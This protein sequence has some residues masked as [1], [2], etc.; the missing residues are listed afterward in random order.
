MGLPGALDPA[1]KPLPAV[2]DPFAQNA[3]TSVYEQYGYAG[4]TWHTYDLG[5]GGSVRDPAAATDTMIGNVLLSCAVWLT[6]ATNGL[7]NKVA[8]PASYMGPLDDVV[9]TVT[10]RLHDSIWSPWGTVAVLGVGALLLFQAMRAHFPAVVAGAAWAALVLAVVA[11]ITQYPSRAS[12]FFDDTITSTIGSMQART[13]G[14]DASTT[15]GESS[16]RAQ[17]A[18]TVDRVLYDAWLRGQL[19]SSDSFAA[20][21]WGSALFQASA[22]SWSE[23]ESASTPEAINQL[24]EEKAEQWKETADEIA[25]QDPA[26]YA[27]LQGK[28][29]GRMGTGLMALFGAVF[30]DLFRLVADVFLLAG[31]VMLRLL[32]MFLP[33]AAVIGVFAPLSG[34]VKQMANMGGA[35]VVN[36]VAFSAGSVVYTAAI[37]AVLSTA[38]DIGMGVMVLVLCLVITLA[39]FV[40]MAPLLS[41]TRILGHSGRRMRRRHLG[42]QLTRYVVTRQ[43]VND[44][45]KKAIED[46]QAEAPEATVPTEGGGQRAA[47]ASPRAETF[48]R[49]QVVWDVTSDRGLSRTSVS[50]QSRV[51]RRVPMTRAAL[52]VSSDVRPDAS[53]SGQRYEGSS[54]WR[55]SAPT[56]ASKDGREPC[57]MPPLLDVPRSSHSVLTGQILTESLDRGGHRS[58]GPA[59]DGNSE[60][61]DDGLAYFVYDPRTGAMLHRGVESDDQAGDAS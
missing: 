1:P 15:P 32:V 14:V 25:E 48:A 13:A 58:T 5:C 21:R 46:T 50:P 45:T 54:E 4:L 27:I 10:S 43:G 57:T 24:N 41:F 49:A 39:A 22:V 40:L 18:L 20:D 12:G 8:D 17:G 37:S 47:E 61:T 38:D 51:D 53:R 11:A 9:E 34:V 29:G 16:A 2:A 23:A 33:A 26:T 7:H 3:G 59:H 36:V 30:V 56:V 19:G 31:L 52:P 55:S 28:A 42:R 6:A 60:L 44:G 35:A